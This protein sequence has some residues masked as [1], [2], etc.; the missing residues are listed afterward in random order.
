MKFSTKKGIHFL[1]ILF[2]ITLISCQEEAKNADL[3][4]KNAT[5]WTGNSNQPTA[6]AKSINV[7]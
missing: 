1:L 5:I 7:I 6:E 4:I 3:I 2:L